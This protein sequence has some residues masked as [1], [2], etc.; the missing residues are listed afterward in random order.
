MFLFSMISR[1]Q[2]R[3]W[4]LCAA[5]LAG[6]LGGAFAT[7]KTTSSP[8]IALSPPTNF[9]ASDNYNTGIRVSWDSSLDASY[10]D[11][12][13]GTVNNL[14]QAT[15]RAH[16]RIVRFND[17]ETTTGVTYYYWVY[18]RAVGLTSNPAGPATGIRTLAARFLKQPPGNLLADAGTVQTITCTT[19][20][21]PT[22]TYQWYEGATMLKN[23][24]NI[25]GVTTST[26]TFNPLEVRDQGSRYF[27]RI[28]NAD[29]VS[30]SRFVNVEVIRP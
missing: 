28:K 21:I 23:Q 1:P 9:K 12:Y 19:E 10:Y 22:V 5:L 18:A 15:L 13:R 29:G 27:V 26:L 17:R 3:H 4:L 11:L 7:G 24:G 16:V 8:I 14:A 25:S 2:P 20:G 6:I 30:N